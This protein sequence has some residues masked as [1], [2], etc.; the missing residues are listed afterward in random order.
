MDAAPDPTLD[1]CWQEVLTA[2]GDEAV[3]GAFIQRCRDLGQLGYA[4]ARYRE[5]AR[6][7][8]A[9]RDDGE[10]AERAQRQIRAITAFALLDLEATRAQPVSMRRLILRSVARWGLAA[11]AV[12]VLAYVALNILSR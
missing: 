6:K 7:T 11:L 3:H 10:R 2:W 9:Y 12:C 8:T 5:E 1:A 4:A